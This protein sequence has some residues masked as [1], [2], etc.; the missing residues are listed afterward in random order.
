MAYMITLTFADESEHVVQLADVNRAGMLK[1]RRCYGALASADSKA[2][3]LTLGGVDVDYDAVERLEAEGLAASTELLRLVT[4]P[5]QQFV[6]QV[7]ESG[8]PDLIGM[9]AA[10][11]YAR[12]QVLQ[13]Q[14][15]ANTLSIPKA[16]PKLSAG[17]SLAPPTM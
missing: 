13:S 6:E 7:I 8:K 9:V 3:D 17:T 1:A 15:V 11:C 5:D 16:G 14:V 12:V 2:K 4:V 10:M